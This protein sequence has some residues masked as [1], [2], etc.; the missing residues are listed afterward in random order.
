MKKEVR[1]STQFALCLDNEGYQA[2][3]QVGKLYRVI[4]DK[5]AENHGYVRIVDESGED[6]AFDLRR[7]H[8][9]TL[10][11]PVER[12]LLQHHEGTF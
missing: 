12:A 8:F 11:S 2:S 3:L 6:Y 10:P 5:D 7:F 9:V 4:P 1:R